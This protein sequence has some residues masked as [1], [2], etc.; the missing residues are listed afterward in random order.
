MTSS[1]L[2]IHGAKIVTS[3]GIRDGGVVAANGRIV[4]LLN[5]TDK[6]TADTVIDARGRLL[7]AGFVDAHVHMRD[8]G[9]TLKEDFA[10]GSTAAAVGGV[11]TVMCMPNTKPPIDSVVAFDL[12]R[13]AGERVSYVDFA[14]QATVHPQN[15]PAMVSL[16]DAGAVS[17]ETMLADGPPGEAYTSP[18]ALEEMLAQAAKLGVRVGI[19][20]GSQE[21]IDASLGRLRAA[22]R[23]DFLAFAESRPPESEALG[24]K[25]LVDAQRTTAASIIARQVSTA[26]GFRIV[27]RAKSQV[28]A[29]RIRVEVTPHHLQ[30]D[31]GTLTRLGPYAQMLPPL[32]SVPD[33]AAAQRAAA[34]GTVDFIGSD[35]APHTVAEKEVADPWSS[36]SGTPG[37]DTLAAAVLDL[38]ARQIISYSRIA[39]LLAEQPA[40]VFGL[41]DRKGRIAIGADADLVVVDA[42]ER[43]HVTPDVVRSRAARSPFEGKVLRGRPVLTVLRGEVIAE[44][45]R[46]VANRPAGRFLSRSL[47]IVN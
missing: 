9:Q 41:A 8:P 6:A 29:G 13:R 15:Y 25:Q 12:A 27:A 3:G 1:T 17:F 5:D 37:L 21:M 45:G 14:L 33:V 4:E 23:M 43:F 18:K 19:Y 32:R 16:W 30:L 11:T 2:C 46:L 7:F 34:D 40:Q 31:V 44:N 36:P 42:Q 24:L 28:P 20:C 47:A 26:Q 38:A 39:A 35:H 22:G 10:S